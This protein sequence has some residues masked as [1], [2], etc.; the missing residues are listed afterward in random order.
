[1]DK[2]IREYISLAAMKADEYQYWQGRSVQERM[3]VIDTA[4]GLKAY[5]ISGGDLLNAKRAAG[6]PRDIADAYAIR[7]SARRKGWSFGGMVRVLSRRGHL[8]RGVQVV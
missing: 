6:R 3:D 4:T 8:R 1:M 5:F 2:T 7:E